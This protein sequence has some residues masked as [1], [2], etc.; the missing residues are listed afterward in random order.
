MLLRLPYDRR[1]STETNYALPTWYARQGF[2]V[3][4]QDTRGRYASGGEFVPF[5]HEAAD[6]YDTVEWAARLEGSNGKVGMYG[7]SYSGYLQLLTAAAQPPSLGAI[8]PAIAGCDL[9]DGWLYEGGALSLSFSAWWAASLGLDVARRRDDA[10]L[11]DRLASAI[12]DAWRWY[13]SAR[14]YDLAPIATEIRSSAS[15]STTPRAT[16]TGRSVAPR[17]C[18]SASPSRRCT[19]AA[20]TTASTRGRCV[21]S[22]A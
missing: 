7:A 19:S 17:R 1:V 20:G 14:P 16:T 22:S 13:G 3:V 9:Y 12:G 5:I 15:G 11:E 6:G 8:C 18:T 2:I 4:I 21:T 10:G